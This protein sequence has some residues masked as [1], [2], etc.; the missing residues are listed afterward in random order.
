MSAQ[1]ASEP[2]VSML[3][4]AKWWAS[5][6]HLV[7]P[8]HNPVPTAEGLACSCG[9]A[10]GNEAK[11]PRTPNGLLDATSDQGQIAAWWARW[12]N[13]NI[14]IRTGITFDLLDIDG[15]A[16]RE[17]M[18]QLVADIGEP[19]S[20]AVVTSG[21]EG[22]G[23]HHYVEPA[24]LKALAQGKTAPLGIDVKGDGGYVVAPPSQ[25]ITGRRY[26]WASPIGTITGT[27]P[28]PDFHAALRARAPAR[29]A[30]PDRPPPH[31]FDSIPP[32]AGGGGDAYGRA[33]LDRLL[34]EA[35][36]AVEGNRW[37]TF[38]TETTWQLARAIAGGRLDRTALSEVQDAALAAGLEPA[39]VRRLEKILD[40]AVGKVHTPVKPRDRAP[41]PP[42]MPEQEAQETPW[43]DPVP[44]DIDV[45]PF[46]TWTLGWLEPDVLALAEHM[47]V[48]VD[49]PAMLTL[50]TLAAT[51][52]G[53]VG[54]EI[55]D[56]WVEPLNLYIA[57][58]AAA[59][60][61]KSPVL[62]KITEELRVME[63]EAQEEARPRIA[64]IKNRRRI[65]EGR[66]KRLELEAV[67]A[68]GHERA[69]AEQ[70]VHRAVEELDAV[71]VPALPR[72]LA[73]DMTAEALIRLLSE[74]GGALASLS[75][76]GGLFDTIAG[77]RYSG[78]LANLDGILQ[79][80][81][82]REP[83]MVDR[84]GGDPIRVE[85]P[86]LTLGLA[87]QPQVV[88]AAGGN[89]AA[90]GRGLLA[91]FLFSHPRSLVGH[92]DMGRDRPGGGFV[93]FVGMIRGVDALAGGGFVGFV[94]NSL[95]VILKSSSSSR[96]LHR[97]YLSDLEPRRHPTRGD[98]GDMTA[99]ANKLDGQIARIAGLLTLL[100]AADPSLGNVPTKPTKP[101]DVWGEN[102]Q[103]PLEVGD[104][105]VIRA[106][107]IADYL[108]GHAL[109]AHALM[110]GGVGGLR[111]PARILLEWASRQ[112]GGEFTARDAHYALRHREGLKKAADVQATAAELCLNGHLRAIAHPAGQPGRPSQR[113]L[114]H[115]DHRA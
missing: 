114:V 84:K 38:A 89:D 63:K 22:G 100:D 20:I 1:P 82:G 62:A 71:E 30:P 66:I 2:G 45:P 51:T 79:A 69:I 88:S 47:Q 65:Q 61:T 48:P 58:I 96:Y 31:P 12:P 4:A 41:E 75:A 33:M 10:C 105:A 97:A 80:H 34:A 5:H 14:G 91:R 18:A 28:W 115:P 19:L 102:G 59:G 106:C 110:A 6:G 64:E 112:P 72:I 83:I 108:I 52:R 11:H 37:H 32:P 17:S 7:L 24:G 53:R 95:K 8:L 39:E 40:D 77:G 21:R 23:T 98:L 111:S 36:Q 50:A 87:V 107:E 42:P 76:E 109:S 70:A 57:V 9:K 29:P 16:G 44:L 85:R 99:W 103:V 49:L 67:K 113:Y 56:G 93:G 86:C 68:A 55:G 73:G 43:D 60:E 25:H 74:Q 3:I 13:A 46:P 15:Q 26:A 101:Q 104:L 94:G 54:I 90:V 35:A 92:R 27:V 81:D 78:G